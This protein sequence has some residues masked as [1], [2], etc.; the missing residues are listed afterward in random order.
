MN[1][2]SGKRIFLDSAGGENNPS[3]IHAEGRKARARLE[4]ARAQL[5]EFLRVQ[6]RDII[7]T[8]GSTESDNL[9]ILGVFEKAKETISVPHI[10]ISSS[11]HPAV[12][13][14]AK[15]A[16]RRGA[17]LSIVPVEEVSN[18]IKENTILVSIVYVENE[19]GKINHISEVAR[20]VAKYRKEKGGKYPLIHTDVTQAVGLL[21]IDT[22][23]LKVDLETLGQALVVRPNVTLHP[24]LFGGGQERGLRPGTQRVAEIERFVGELLKLDKKREGEYQRLKTLQKFFISELEKIPGVI[25]NTPKESLPSIV[26]VSFREK[27]HEFLAVQLDERGISVSTGSSCDSSK[28]EPDKEALRFSFDEETSEKDLRHTLKVLLE[29]LPR[30]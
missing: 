1:W 20:A 2:L 16:K 6:A 7:F 25:V 14:S 11:E 24:I 17:E 12:L 30:A 19:T 29:I 3:S 22:E 8:S 21:P 10:I 9:A 5:A 4:V 18:H 23:R 13:E 15:E 28:D 27:L 26:S